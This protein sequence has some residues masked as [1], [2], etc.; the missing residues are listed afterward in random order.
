MSIPEA[1][2]LSTFGK[3]SALVLEDRN[4]REVVNHDRQHAVV[5]HF[6]EEALNGILVASHGERKVPRANNNGIVCT[7]GLCLLC[8]G[9][10]MLGGTATGTDEE[11]DRLVSGGIEGF[12]GCPNHLRSFFV[13]QV[14]SWGKDQGKGMPNRNALWDAH[15]HR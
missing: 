6:L 7:G 14:G 10:G 3:H 13:H 8:K 15:L 1:A 2:P 11:R 9:N 4:L 5:E 12:P